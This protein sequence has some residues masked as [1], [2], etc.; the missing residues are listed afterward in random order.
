MFSREMLRAGTGGCNYLHPTRTYFRVPF[1]STRGVSS[2]GTMAAQITDPVGLVD[3]LEPD[4]IRDRLADL[5]RQSRALRV[6][7]R[8]AIAR[9]R[10]AQRRHAVGASH[11]GGPGHAA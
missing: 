10:Q 3:Q 1:C 11:E 8:A 2:N 6:L 4:L 9:E 7:L 5:D